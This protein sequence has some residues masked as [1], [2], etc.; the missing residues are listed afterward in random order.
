[1][2]AL[3]RSPEASAEEER[4]ERGEAGAR[5][6]LD[7]TASPRFRPCHPKGRSEAEDPGGEAGGVDGG[8]RGDTLDWP[9]DGGSD[10]LD[11]GSRARGRAGGRDR[12]TARVTAAEA[13]A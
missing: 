10:G 9:A 1:M 7:Q 5:H 3:A 6:E 2:R 12:A 8:E 11:A 13:C 4:T